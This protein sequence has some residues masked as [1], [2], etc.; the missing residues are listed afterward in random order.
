M[1]RA[2]VAEQK[3]TLSLC[4]GV[5]FFSPHRH[6]PTKRLKAWERSS[7]WIATSDVTC[8]STSICINGSYGRV[9]QW[10]ILVAQCSRRRGCI[11]KKLDVIVRLLSSLFGLQNK[12]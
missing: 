5:F 11:S 6:K 9:Y 3:S 1:L 2:T 8:A 4:G 7:P 10:S 12:K